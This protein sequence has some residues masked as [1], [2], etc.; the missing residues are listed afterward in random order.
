[1]K[2]INH[3]NVIGIDVKTT[4][5]NNKSAEE[6][7]KLWERFF[8]EDIANKIPNKLTDENEIFSIYTDY[9][10]NFEGAYRCIIGQR[11]DNLEDI[12]EG[13]TGFTVENGKYEKFTAKGEMPSAVVKKW[14]EIWAQDGTLER[15]Y[16]SDF[17]LY[18]DKSQNGSN[19]IVDIYIAIK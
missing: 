15:A 19:S 10:N 5:E 7:G 9:E 1:M 8:S 18:T 16:T 13:M 4:N 12:P 14:E 6:I 11:V 17:E 3:F 2:I